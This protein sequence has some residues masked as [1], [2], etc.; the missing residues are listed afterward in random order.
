MADESEQAAKNAIEI[1]KQLVAEA[2]QKA[3]EV[4]RAG[5][6]ASDRAAQAAAEIAAFG[7]FT[8]AAVKQMTELSNKLMAQIQAKADETGARIKALQ[9]AAQSQSPKTKPEVKTTKKG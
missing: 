2:A 9:E 4:R 8:V 6:L 3:D 1:F 5:D 7:S